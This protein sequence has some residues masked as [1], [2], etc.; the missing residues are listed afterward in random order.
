[1]IKASYF[2]EDGN[3]MIVLHEGDMEISMPLSEAQDLT[4]QLVE[5]FKN[6][7]EVEH[8]EEGNNED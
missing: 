5:C 2:I 8:G 4:R 3:W 6:I 7:M 1:M